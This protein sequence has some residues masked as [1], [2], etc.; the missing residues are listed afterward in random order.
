M[1]E[2]EGCGATWVAFVAGETRSLAGLL[3]QLT[4]MAMRACIGSVESGATRNGS[5]RL[6]FAAWSSG[7]LDILLM[8]R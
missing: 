8:G 2:V 6:G 3:L 4:P 7:Q 1:R 5:S